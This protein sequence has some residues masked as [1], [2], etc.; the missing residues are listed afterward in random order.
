LLGQFG[1]VG[2]TGKHF[3]LTD[4]DGTA[5]TFN[6]SGGTASV[7]RDGSAIDLRVVDAGKGVSLT[8]NAKGGDGRLTLGNVDVT[9]SIKKLTGK[10]ADLASTLSATGTIGTLTLGDVAGK[11]TAAGGNIRSLS[12]SSLNGALILS[13]A[14]LAANT[15]AAGLIGKLSVSGPISG[16][17]IGAGLNPVNGDFGDDDDIVVGGASSV[18]NSITTRG[19]V[20][21][22]TRFVA[23]AFGNARIPKSVDP[24]TDPR[25]RML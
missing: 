14:D 8:V 9:G 3:T 18:I 20:D 1:N 19:L 6:L 13:G 17:L 24:T 4:D 23:G 21:A 2:T 11:V 10:T 12:A 15:F 16:S 7:F 22:S 5:I 25:F